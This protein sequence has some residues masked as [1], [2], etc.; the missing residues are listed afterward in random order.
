MKAGRVIYN[1]DGT[2]AGADD[3]ANNHAWRVRK[4]WDTAD[5]TSDAASFYMTTIEEVTEA[6]IQNIRD[7]YE[8]DWYNW[9]APWGAP[10]NDV[11]GNGSFD[12][13]IDIPGYPGAGQTIWVISNDVPT[14]VDENGNPIDNNNTAPQLYGSEPVGVELQVT[15][16]AYELDSNKPL[17]NAVYKRTQLTYTGFETGS[18]YINP[19]VL[20]TVYFTQWSDPDLGTHTDDFVGCDVD[21]SL[22]FVYNGNDLDGVFNG[23]YDMPAPA[24]GYDFLKSPEDENGIELGMTAFT[25]FGAGSSISDPDLSSYSGSLQFF[26]LMEGFLPRP[27]YPAQVPWIDPISEEETKFA[28]NG[29]PT[30]GQGWIDGIEL[31]PGD[32]RL[33]MSSGPFSMTKGESQEII[34][35]VVGAQRINRIES[36]RKLK[37]DDEIVQLAYDT[38]YNL[39]DYNVNTSVSE[40]QSVFTLSLSVDVSASVNTVNATLNNGSGSELNIVLDGNNNFSIQTDIDESPSPYILSLDLVL[41]SGLSYSL[42]SLNQKAIAWDPIIIS[43]DQVIYDN[44]SNDG[45]LNIGDLAQISLTVTNSSDH[46]IE[47]L[48]AM[49]LNV[50]GPIDYLDNPYL[51]FDNIASNGNASSSVSVGEHGYFTV[52]VSEYA[53]EGDTLLLALRFFDLL[54]NI[55]ED[56]YELFI[57]GNE[58][59]T[60]FIEPDHVNG[61][62]DGNFVYR[63]V[64]P[65]DVTDHQYELSFSIHDWSTG[66]DLSGSNLSGIGYI[67]SGDPFITFEFL[68]DIIA[69]DYNYSDGIRLTF[70]E[71]TII[72]G[73]AEQSEGVLAMVSDNEVM[74][75]DSSQS[76]SGYFTGGQILHVYVDTSTQAPVDVGYVIYDDGW[77]QWWCASEEDGGGGNCETCESYGIG[78]DCNGEILSEAVNAE[79]SIN[80]P[81][82][83]EHEFS[84]G[85]ILLNVKDV[86]S[87]EIVLTT[88]DLPDENGFNIDIIDGFKLFKGTVI[89]GVADDVNKIITCFDLDMPCWDPANRPCPQ[90]CCDGVY[91]INSYMTNGWA[92]TARAVDTWGSGITSPS[93]LGRDVQIRFTGVYE[94]E[95]IY[96]N[97]VYYFQVQQGTGSSAWIDGARQYDFSQHPDPNNP[98]TGSPFRLQIPFEVWDMEAPDGPQQIDITIYDRNQSMNEG[99]TVYAFNPYNR[100]YTHFIMKPH[101]E[102]ATALDEDALTWNVV[103]WQTDWVAGD[104]ITFEYLTPVST[105]D[106]YLF[107]PSTGSFRHIDGTIP[108]GYNLAQNYPNPFNPTTKIDYGLPEMSNVRLII[109]DILGREVTTLVNGMQKPGYKSITWHGTDAFG[110]NVGAGMY[111][112]LIQAGEFRQTKKMVLLK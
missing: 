68:V 80:I 23:I 25:Y 107:T 105:E 21:L 79:G 102:S 40:D 97:G 46:E 78:E 1:S 72:Y 54:G 33:V 99:D 73:A 8:Y 83:V 48:V 87:N 43:D 24:G 44:L 12:P 86:T 60:D 69:P 37:K 95:P 38:D 41:S 31:P 11:D 6:Q 50:D 58:G 94:S 76:T 53:Q 34:V 22:G 55:W 103:W 3:P 28:L 17:G 14:I 77:A 20:D 85:A 47:E 16:W 4:Y 36:L 66:R 92:E 35:A 75:G 7:Q 71:G 89:Y 10:Y 74:F 90:D 57:Q 18:E 88:A 81:E 101:A 98:G 19:E 67:T 63:V 13:S 106:R 109:Y 82:I 52:K 65:D 93:L 104:I 56:E 42:D 30:T 9:P 62:A 39:L 15:I 29:D 61:S 32:R 70:P 111:F 84:D 100:M 110:K 64:R 26:N 112:Y 108:Y 27:E 59:I 49:V 5:L 91:D 96:V 45:V 51:S 2:V